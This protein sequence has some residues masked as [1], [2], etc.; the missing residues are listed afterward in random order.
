[1]SNCITLEIDCMKF[2]NIFQSSHSRDKKIGRFRSVRSFPE[3]KPGAELRCK[4]LTERGPETRSTGTAFLFFTRKS[5][6]VRMKKRKITACLK[7]MILTVHILDRRPMPAFFFCFFSF[8][9]ADG[10]RSMLQLYKLI[11]HQ[12][13]AVIVCIALFD[14]WFEEVSV[15]KRFSLNNKDRLVWTT[16]QLLNNRRFPVPIGDAFHLL[17]LLSHCSYTLT[18]MLKLFI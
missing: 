15:T 16:I 9:G 18:K 4:T 17:Y 10:E 11:K 7:L 5:L 13:L 1:M 2:K 12:T 3:W 8:I 14:P 6:C